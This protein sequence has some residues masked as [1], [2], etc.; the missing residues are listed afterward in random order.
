MAAKEQ[1][2]FIS[3]ATSLQP[4]AVKSAVLGAKISQNQLF[5]IWTKDKELTKDKTFVLGSEVNNFMKINQN[6]RNYLNYLIF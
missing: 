1:E 3:L 2:K 5:E 4:E 6:Y